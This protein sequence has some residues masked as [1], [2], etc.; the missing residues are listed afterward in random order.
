MNILLINPEFP[1]TFWGFRHA[2]K[3]ISKRA[4]YP[5]LGLL[6]VAALF[7]AGWHKR[8]VDMNVEVLSDRDIAWA[9][10][11]C[12][13]GMSIQSSSAR[14]TV[15]RAKRAGKKII[16]GGPL[17]TVHPE[18]FDDVD[19]LVLDEAEL[20]LP[21][22]L[23]DLAAGR[24]R[25][26]YDT[27]ERADVK[28]TPT[29]LWHLV[30]MRRYGSMNLQYSRGCPYDCEFCDITV[31]YGRRPRTKTKNQ[32]IA[33]LEALYHAGWRGG[34]FFVDDNFIGNRNK[35]RKEILPAIIDWTVR[36]DHPFMFNTE[37]SIN[38]SDDEELMALM[39][40][41]GFRTVFIGI[42]SPNPESLA[43][44]NKIPN[45]DRDLIA[46]V[47]KIQRSGLQVQG[48]FIVGF[49]SDPA[50]IFQRVVEFVQ[51]SG[52]VT[53]MVGLLN[54]PVGTR[55]YNRLLEEGR[56]LKSMT[57]D[58]T[59]FSMNFIPRM[60]RESLMKGYRYLLEHIYSPRPYYA[61]VKNFLKTYR[62][63]KV[64]SVALTFAD[65]RA[66]LSSTVILG[67][68]GKERVQYWKLFLW[69]L[70]TRPRLFPMAITFAIYGH[71]FRKILDIY[72]AG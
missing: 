68:V 28:A 25:H 65:I 3:F 29:P 66:L 49:D 32:V 34:V 67:L 20:T 48:G 43:E 7:P 1:D 15:E 12:I 39:T 16:A 24:P 8:L 44:C 59:D 55:L 2:L 17:F 10:F 11:V 14:D 70:F 45:K 46:A 72:A 50:S 64:K 56:L 57:G 47:K 61:R 19:Y 37:V 53:A 58:N 9:D 52:I 22:F 62:P 21:P 54:A 41:A 33:E 71:H 26:R 42:E 5:P 40:K 23:D 30:D 60:S 35:L 27:P 6:T 63:P 38:L 31:L 51:E 69:S 4:A 13:G 36:R 18:E